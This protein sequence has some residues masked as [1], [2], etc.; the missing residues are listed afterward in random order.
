MHWARSLWLS[1]PLCHPSIKL[2]AV[3]CMLKT[4]LPQKQEL[5]HP[6]ARATQEA[7][8]LQDIFFEVTRSPSAKLWYSVIYI[9]TLFPTRRTSLP[10][11]S[12]CFACGARTSLVL[13]WQGETLPLIKCP[14]LAC[15]NFRSNSRDMG[16][17]ACS[18]VKKGI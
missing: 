13:G 2:Y 15:L 14:D 11:Q 12:C 9:P 17:A 5:L 8:P 10:G 7:L 16:H 18:S 6:S 4:G 3:C 1:R